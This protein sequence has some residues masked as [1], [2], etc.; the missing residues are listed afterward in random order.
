MRVS[1]RNKKQA[2]YTCKLLVTGE[3]KLFLRNVIALVAI[4]RMPFM[5]KLFNRNFQVCNF[6]VLTEK[7]ITRKSFD[8]GSLQMWL[9][10]Y[11]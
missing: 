5:Q 9:Y 2:K 4:L 10:L 6:L 7:R 11:F 1:I 3:E 8:H